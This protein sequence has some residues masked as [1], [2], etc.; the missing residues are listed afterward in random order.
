MDEFLELI[1][2]IRFVEVDDFYNRKEYIKIK[3]QELDLNMQEIYKWYFYFQFC[4]LKN[5]LKEMLWTY[6]NQ[7]EDKSFNLELEHRYKLFCMGRKK[8]KLEELEFDF[9]E[10]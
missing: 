7:S 9:F 3:Y 8:Q 2:D 5:P 10:E 6:L 1:S 4:L